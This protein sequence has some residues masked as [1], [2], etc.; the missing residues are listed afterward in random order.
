MKSEFYLKGFSDHLTNWFQIN[1]RNL[2]WRKSKDPYKIWISEIMLQQTRVEAVIDYFNRWTKKWPNITLLAKASENDVL[3]AWQGLGYYSRARNILKTANLIV[4]DYNGFFPTDV[5]ELQKLPGIGRYTAGAISSIAYGLKE[6][7]VDGN[8]AR[9][10]ARIFE[11]KEIV[12]DPRSQNLFYQI[13]TDLLPTKE[14]SSFNQGLMELGAL[15]CV[16]QNPRC[17]NCPVAKHCQSFANK[18]TDIFPIRKKSAK[19]EKIKRIVI[20]IKKNNK[21]FMTKREQKGVY[22]GMWE[23]PGFTIDEEIIKT[24][25]LSE[26]IRINLKISGKTGEKLNEFTHTFTKFKETIF[27]YPFTLEN[28]EIQL[29]GEW[30]TSVKVKE[31]PMG[32][33]QQK[34]FNFVFGE[35]V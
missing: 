8:V 20:V 30:V 11:R 26:L 24:K 1:C 28:K 25:E 27:V 23:F 14:V 15:I 12:N 22:F 35:K 13:A 3:N 21:V 32:S 2:P 34:I 19:T 18:T 6:P 4:S 31:M 5:A 16:P 10:Y 9:V 29:P 33:V 17:Q 7:I